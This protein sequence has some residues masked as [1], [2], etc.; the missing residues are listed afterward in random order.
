MLTKMHIRAYQLRRYAAA[1]NFS[2]EDRDA[3]AF[4]VARAEG[5]NVNSQSCARF[6]HP[7]VVMVRASAMR[8]RGTLGS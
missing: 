8:Y 3:R 2:A 4:A 7:L 1:E 5:L 6:M